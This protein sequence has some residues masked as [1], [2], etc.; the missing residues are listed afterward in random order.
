MTSEPAPDV[1]E[2]DADLY[3]AAN[4]LAMR[5]LAGDDSISW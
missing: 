4:L 3:K 2:R 1:R 5:V